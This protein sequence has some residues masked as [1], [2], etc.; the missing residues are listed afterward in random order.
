MLKNKSLILFIGVGFIVTVLIW[1]FVGGCGTTGF[2]FKATPPPSQGSSETEGL[3]LEETTLG[4][5]GAVY[6]VK[7][8]DTL[9]GISRRFGVSVATIK[10]A[11]NLTK[12]TI[13]V[14]Q[15]LIIPVEEAPVVDVEP[16]TVESRVDEAKGDL[17]VYKIRKGDSLWRIAQI[18][19][20]TIERIVE[21]NGIPR[22]A[23][24]RPG[25][26]LLIPKGE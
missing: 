12:E 20:T 5:E 7:A 23:R 15:Q 2:H 16:L 9:W 19:G 11:N 13:I 14:G 8:G 25:Q 10:E 6:I 22:N 24:L 3:I 18:H 17:V 4:V 26:E 1:G 21:L